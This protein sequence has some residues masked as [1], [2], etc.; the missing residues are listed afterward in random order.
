MINI[1]K[2]NHSF[3]ILFKIVWKPSKPSVNANT[4]IFI[5]NKD[6]KVMTIWEKIRFLL[7]EASNYKQKDS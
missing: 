7:K 1:L 5:N 3:S 4:L 6:Q 2:E